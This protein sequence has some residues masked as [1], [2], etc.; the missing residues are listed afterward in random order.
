MAATFVKQTWCL[1]SKEMEYFCPCIKKNETY[2][3][4]C[5]KLLKTKKNNGFKVD[6]LKGDG[7]GFSLSNP[8]S[9]LA[10]RPKRS[11]HTLSII[12]GG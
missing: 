10:R 8:L 5:N 3:N 9:P 7:V 6:L 1:K 11:F 4:S 2:M 12:G